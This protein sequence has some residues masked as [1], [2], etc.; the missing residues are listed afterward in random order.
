MV[1]NHSAKIVLMVVINPFAL[2]GQVSSELARL[3]RSVSEAGRGEINA[4]AVTEEVF[5]EAV[6]VG[7]GPQ[8][9]RRAYAKFNSVS[10]NYRM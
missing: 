8:R 10:F 5:W 4:V 3:F 9:L 7:C 1:I 6:F 2:T